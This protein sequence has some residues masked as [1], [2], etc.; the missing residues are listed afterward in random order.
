M[1]VLSAVKNDILENNIIVGSMLFK[2]SS[3]NV[4]PYCKNSN[5]IAQQ[6]HT[7]L[8]YLV[9]WQ[10]NGLTELDLYTSARMGSVV[11]TMTPTNFVS[12]NCITV[13]SVR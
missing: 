9:A 11:R 7:F 10:S 3:L 5:Q 4:S 8:R 12:F 2:H 6:V 1:A 13:D